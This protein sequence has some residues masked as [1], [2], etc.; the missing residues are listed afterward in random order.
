MI[1]VSSGSITIQ[2]VISAAAADARGR[3]WAL[4]TERDLEAER[5]RAAGGR[6]A[7]EEGA[8]VDVAIAAHRTPLTCCAATA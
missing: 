1:T 2:A 5:Q 7:G 6:D 4:R 8:A 3:A